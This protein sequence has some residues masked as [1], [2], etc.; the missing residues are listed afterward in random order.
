MALLADAIR[1]GEPRRDFIPDL[2]DLL[3][4]KRMQMI[5]RRESLDAPKARIIQAPRQ[6]HVAVHPVLAD[7]ERGKTHPD[8]ESN[9][10][11]LWQNRDRPVLLRDFQQLV[12]DRA[13]TFRLTGK[14]RRQCMSSTGVRLIAIGEDAMAA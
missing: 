3:E 7:D 6:N 8:L 4:S 9:P 5:S 13:N 1:L 11:F 2:I 14:V 12:E 10:R